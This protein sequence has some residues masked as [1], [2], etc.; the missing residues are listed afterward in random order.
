MG[1]N[2]VLLFFPYRCPQFRKQFFVSCTFSHSEEPHFPAFQ[3]ALCTLPD[4]NMREKSKH[5]QNCNAFICLRIE[6]V[7]WEI[8]LKTPFHSSDVNLC[9][10]LHAFSHNFRIHSKIV[11]CL[12]ASRIFK[13]DWQSCF[14]GNNV[15]VC[16]RSSPGTCLYFISQQQRS[17]HADVCI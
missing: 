16:N 1:N 14:L 8:Q 11:L 9:A 6:K 7:S 2:Y 15:N 10:T 3:R 13:I 4:F 5:V 17:E 12:F